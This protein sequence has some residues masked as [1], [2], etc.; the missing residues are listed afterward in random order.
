MFS[1]PPARDVWGGMGTLAELTNVP[2]GD[3]I[4][5]V[6]EAQM[7]AAF[8]RSVLNNASE[9]NTV[10]DYYQGSTADFYSKYFHSISQG[11]VCYGFCYDDVN[12]QS[13]T[14]TCSSPRGIVVN[15]NW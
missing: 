13:S 9:L 15:V 3:T 6:L 8:H 14:L 12:N 2:A 1:N 7:T 10:S 5:L 11:G 4:E